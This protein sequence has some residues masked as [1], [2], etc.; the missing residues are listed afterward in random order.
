MDRIEFRVQGSADDPYHVVFRLEDGDLYAECNCEAGLRGMYC[1][2][3]LR[4][5]DGEAT[6]IVSENIGDIGTVSKW[7]KGTKLESALKAVWE[8]EEAVAEAQR[9]LR[10]A[11]KGLARIMTP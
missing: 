6:D 9:G 10:L 5:L 7:L 1:K 11:K 8:H 3:R 4:I 2:H